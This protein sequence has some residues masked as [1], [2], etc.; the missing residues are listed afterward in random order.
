MDGFIIIL[1]GWNSSGRSSD[2]AD[3]D[4]FRTRLFESMCISPTIN[5][6][7]TSMVNKQGDFT[8]LIFRL[9]CWGTSQQRAPVDSAVIDSIF[10]VP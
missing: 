1:C 6:D 4:Q 7:S 3:Q 2:D 9:Q 10:Y 8:F 5:I